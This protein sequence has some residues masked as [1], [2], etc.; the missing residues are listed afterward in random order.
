MSTSPVMT[1]Q[2]ITYDN[3]SLGLVRTFDKESK[4]V[5]TV[6]PAEEAIKRTTEEKDKEGVVT[7]TPEGEL[8]G[9]QSFK[10]PSAGSLT[11]AQ[12]LV[13]DEKELVLL[14]NRGLSV[15]LQN[16][17]RALIKTTDDEDNPNFEF[18]EEAFDLREY[19]SIPTSRRNL[20]PLDKAKNV[21]AEAMKT[22]PPEQLAALKAMFEQ[23]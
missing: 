1:E 3:Y 23:A 6:Y 22:L 21:L 8:I 11:G 19:A 14:F 18:A 15:K 5:Y 20:S 9:T 10:M 12:E 17:A 13:P 16:K 7:K 2:P 4:P